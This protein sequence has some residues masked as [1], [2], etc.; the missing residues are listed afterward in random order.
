MDSSWGVGG[1]DAENQGHGRMTNYPSLSW[2]KGQTQDFQL[3]KS[4]IVWDKSVTQVRDKEDF[5]LET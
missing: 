4:Q 1:T 5:F 3:G 2:V